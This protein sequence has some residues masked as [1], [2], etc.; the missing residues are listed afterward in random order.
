MASFQTFFNTSGIDTRLHTLLYKITWKIDS[1]AAC[2]TFCT[3]K[4]STIFTHKQQQW[5]IRIH[6][7][8]SNSPCWMTQKDRKTVLLWLQLKARRFP[9]MNDHLS[10][11]KGLHTAMVKSTGDRFINQ[12][13]TQ[14]QFIS[15]T[16]SSPTV[17][18]QIVLLKKT[19]II[20]SATS[21][22]F[23]WSGVYQ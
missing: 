20:I 16:I 4:P 15:L 17:I 10:L 12:R 11:F 7:Q 19:S 3:E 5:M 22:F 23:H 21:H 2:I 14:E 6:T 9:T 13:G 1:C 18:F 8:Y